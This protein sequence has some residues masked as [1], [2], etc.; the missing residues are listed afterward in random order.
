MKPS[1]WKSCAAC[2]GYKQ[3]DAVIVVVDASNLQRNLYLV[4]QLI[5]LGRPMVVALNMM[6]VAER[7]G[8]KVSPEIG[9]KA[10]RAGRAGR[11]PQAARA[12]RNSKPRSATPASRRCPIGRC[13]RRCKEE[14]LV[15]GGGLA[16]L[17]SQDPLP[18]PVLRERAGVRVRAKDVNIEGRQLARRPTLTFHR[19]SANDEYRERGRR[20][21]PRV[22]LHVDS[23]G[24][25][26]DTRPSPSGCSLAIAHADIAP[27]AE[28]EP[29]ASLLAQ[30][31]SRLR[32][33]GHRPDAG[34]CRGALSL[35]R[36]G[37]PIAQAT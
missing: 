34:G 19:I 27:I 26:I 37:A 3:P 8:I 23:I 22:D 21:P 31:S 13:R 1:R 18:R 4:S 15:V 36:G 35:D 10:R 32:V 25:W 16:I 11:R 33:A 6:D 14:L 9:E 12:S 5:E 20:R 17:D 7:R 28:R 2:A 30:A 29:V 24:G